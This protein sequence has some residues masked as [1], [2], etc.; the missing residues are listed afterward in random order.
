[1]EVKVSVTNTDLLFIPITRGGAGRFADYHLVNTVLLIVKMLTEI[2]MQVA[3]QI[4]RGGI[5]PQECRQLIEIAVIHFLH[6]LF[7]GRLDIPK[8]HQHA[9][10]I[11]GGSSYENFHVPIVAMQ[12][13]TASVITDQPVGS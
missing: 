11:D 13:R 8:I 7:N 4:F 9:Q 6:H 5:I 10:L 1:M 12:I 2:R 3:S